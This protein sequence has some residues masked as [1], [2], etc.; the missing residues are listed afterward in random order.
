MK[1]RPYDVMDIAIYVINKTIDKGKPVNEPTLQNLL[2]QIQL[3]F[4]NLRGVK[5]FI[6]SEVLI[7]DEVKILEVYEASNK[8]TKRT[9]PY[10][11]S[12]KTLVVDG[13]L[14]VSYQTNYYCEL[15][16]REEDKKLIDINIDNYIQ[17][18]NKKGVNLKEKLDTIKQNSITTL[19]EDKE[20]IKKLFDNEYLYESLLFIK[21]HTMKDVVMR[22]PFTRIKIVTEVNIQR[23]HSSIVEISIYIKH[24]GTTIIKYYDTYI[25]KRDVDEQLKQPH[26][27]K[28]I[29]LDSD[30]QDKKAK[31]IKKV[32]NFANKNP[33]AFAYHVSLELDKIINKLKKRD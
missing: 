13:D 23:I 20:N 31:I 21:Q 16:I 2:K 22:I 8:Y 32:S 26:S 30:N 14:E 17:K 28:T 1:F 3:T 15:K 9:I 7:D 4:V 24:S 6:G 29:H 27:L 5:C 25:Y 33:N 10:Q 11:E 12:Y 18:D 19:E